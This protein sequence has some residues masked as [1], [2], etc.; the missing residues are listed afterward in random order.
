MVSCWCWKKVNPVSNEGI[1][2]IIYL[3]R[4]TKVYVVQ[5]TWQAIAGSSDP[6]STDTEPSKTEAVFDISGPQQLPSK[7]SPV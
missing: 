4:M 1:T 6:S 2:A 3:R 5:L 7:L